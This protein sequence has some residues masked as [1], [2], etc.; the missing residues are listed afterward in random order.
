MIYNLIE[1]S[2]NWLKKI[3]LSKQLMLSS[4]G[5]KNSLDDTANIC[6]FFL[7]GNC[8]FGVKCF[9]KHV[10]GVQVKSGAQNV[11]DRSDST[12]DAEKVK[13]A[14][15]SVHNSGN[16]HLEKK[17][18]SGSKKKPP[19]KTAGD[20]IS[21]IQW[22]EELS[23]KDFVVGYLDRFIGIVEK[24]FTDLSW[25]NLASVDH[26]VDLA[27]PRHRIQ[28]FK[29]HGEIVWD[30]REGIDRVFG[31]TGSNETIL[32]VKERIST[33]QNSDEEEVTEETAPN[34]EVISNASEP[35]NV[36]SVKEKNGPNYF[37]AI[38]ISDEGIINN[39]NKIQ[40]KIQLELGQEA[41]YEETSSQSLHITLLMLT[42][43]NEDDV[44]TAKN[45]LKSIQPL[46]VS[47][48]PL[49]HKLQINGLGQF[50]NR[51]LYAKVDPDDSLLKIVQALKFKFGKAGISLEGN[52]DQF[53]PHLTVMRGRSLTDELLRKL[54]E[55]MK[56]NLEIG[57]QAVDS[58]ILFS[59]YLP[60]TVDGTHQKILAVENS[61]K[62]LSS[63]LPT[64]FCQY[65]DHLFGNKQIC[66]DER[67]KIKALFQSGNATEMDMGLARL[68]ELRN[69]VQDMER[70]LLIL[71][72]IPGSGKTHL[73]ENL[74]EARE[75]GGFTYC[76]S[77]QLFHKKGALALDICEL[78]I[79][80]AYCR[81]CFLD[82]MA[83]LCPFV[84]VD[85]VHAKCW[86]YAVYKCLGQAF[87]YT[88]HV[89]EIRVSEPEDIKSCHQNCDSELQ[90]KQLL[91]YVQEWE[92]DTTATIIKPWFTNL[93]HAKFTEPVS[94][95][96]LLKK[97]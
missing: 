67:N 32:D 49:S 50:H 2:Q 82:A 22:D 78:N 46:L 96:E 58:L 21:R 48:L 84:V 41:E 87:G 38:Q 62:V 74:E 73:V 33:S 97:F 17:E 25:E 61:L 56:S 75:P 51:I 19:M 94:L 39:I 93:D 88:C 45:I 92:E 80:E 20:V 83:N 79:A 1:E 95:K 3:E 90:L 42:L 43:K 63:T 71:R 37:I 47:L 36:R 53:V 68:T 64:K 59:K 4:H 34:V 69:S 24:D 6:K 10:E 91:E 7:D 28:Y 52:R 31:S 26:F 23:P 16:M 81:S 57:Q 11:E 72:G 77:R 65:A 40:N 12:N 9:N 29:Y 13:G 66:E 5:K 30:K 15:K 14:V 44:T 35:L 8:R 18:V 27:I 60:K 55:T 76:N 89:L 70:V 54:A 86:E 85:D